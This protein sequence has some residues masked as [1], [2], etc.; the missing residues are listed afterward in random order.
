MSDLAM[1]A[2]R[3]FFVPLGITAIT[4]SVMRGE[5]TLFGEMHQETQATMLLIAAW[6]ALNAVFAKEGG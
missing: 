5:F 1:R 2:G 6:A 3:A 4:I